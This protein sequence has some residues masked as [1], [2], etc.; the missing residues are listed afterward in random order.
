VNHHLVLILS[1]VAYGFRWL[2]YFDGASELE[3]A[4]YFLTAMVFLAAW[5]VLCGIVRQRG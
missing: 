2:A 3:Q 4:K 1:L 5:Y